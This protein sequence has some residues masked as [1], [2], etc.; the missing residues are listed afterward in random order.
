MDWEG[1]NSYLVI[2]FGDVFVVVVGIVTVAV[3]TGDV[4][5]ADD[6]AAT[7]GDATAVAVW[8]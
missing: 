1:A 8:V 3:A 5:V 6:V 7:V 4:A 2:A